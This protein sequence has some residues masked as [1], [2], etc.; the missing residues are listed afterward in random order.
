[1][2][3]STLISF[4]PLIIILCT[5]VSIYFI[6]KKKNKDIWKY[7]F[8]GLVALTGILNVIGIVSLIVYNK[9]PESVGSQAPGQIII[10][11]FVIIQPVFL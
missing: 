10:S 7:L 11:L 3:G 2:A 5:I 8:Y 9:R 4:L 6:A 1:V